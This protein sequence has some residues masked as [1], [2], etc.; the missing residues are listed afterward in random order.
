MQ[1]TNWRK[2]MRFMRII[3]IVLALLSLTME[4]VDQIVARNGFHILPLLVLPLTTIVLAMLIKLP[5]ENPN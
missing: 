1:K 2:T 5:S 3:A 4:L